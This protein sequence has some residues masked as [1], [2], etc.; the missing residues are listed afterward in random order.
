VHCWA[1]WCAPCKAEL[2]HLLARQAVIDADARLVL[3]SLDDDPHA[4]DRYRTA[5]GLSFTS[6]LHPHGGVA[7]VLDLKRSVPR[8][9]VLD[10]H[11]DLRQVLRGSFT[12]G[13]DDK[14]AQLLQ[15]AR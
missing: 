11:G 10:A 2:P 1:T 7:D 6:Y 3:V 14:F 15:R 13:D 9:Y 5:T 4:L 12:W 8:T